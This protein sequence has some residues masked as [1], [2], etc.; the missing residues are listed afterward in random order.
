MA[1]PQDAPQRGSLLLMIP[2]VIT[3]ILIAGFAVALMSNR[4]AKNL[5]VDPS[6]L[7]SAFLGETIPDLTAVPLGD[8]P[9]FASGDLLDGEVKIVNFFASWCPPCRAEHPAL[10]QLAAEG[11]PIYGVN[12]SDRAGDALGF[13]EELGNPYVGVTVDAN[14]RQSLDW[15]V[16]ALPETFVI[17]GEGRV[18]LKFPGPI[19]GVMETIIRPA[20]AEAAGETSG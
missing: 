6:A 11:V 3:A 12:K 14:G 15:G 4:E 18:V 20:L 2:V 16:V 17:D 5:G 9:S 7:P 13:L 1:E 10:M 19:H 8:L